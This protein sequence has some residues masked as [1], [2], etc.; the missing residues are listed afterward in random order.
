LH[1]RH[2]HAAALLAGAAGGQ[3]RGRVAGALSD[4]GERGGLPGQQR[5]VWG[6]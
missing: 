1:L 3:Y 5:G 4:H 6:D 2:D